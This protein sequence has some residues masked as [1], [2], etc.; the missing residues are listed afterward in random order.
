[1]EGSGYPVQVGVQEEEDGKSIRD[2][3]ELEER[4]HF[5]TSEVTQSADDPNLHHNG[6][7]FNFVYISH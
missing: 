6:S 5:S 1:M 3:A 2:G 7:K 4:E